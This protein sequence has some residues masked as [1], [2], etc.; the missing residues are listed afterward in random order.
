M[1]TW[2]K[3]YALV[4]AGAR[5]GQVTLT[6]ATH[7]FP[8]IS[9]PYYL[10][11]PWYDWAIADLLLRECDGMIREA[12]QSVYRMPARTPSLEHVAILRAAGE[13]HALRGEW[14]DA[15]RCS[16]FCLESNQGDSLDHA[17][18]DYVNAA[19]ACLELDD[20][21][22]YLRLRQEMTSRFKD[23]D[24]KTAERVIQVSVMRT[25]DDQTAAR[26]ETLA[27]VLRRA[28]LKQPTRNH[29]EYSQRLALYEYR[30]GNYLDAMDSARR[31]VADV[32]DVALPNAM[33]HVISAMSLQRI[34]NRSAAHLELERAKNLIETGFDLE[35]DMWHWRQWVFVRLLLQE[36]RGSIPQPPPP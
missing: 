33:E 12:E 34:G 36:A 32:R 16:N 7:I 18:M 31:S 3:G 9:E 2:T 5:E 26:L 30:R 8:G 29:T 27:A 11:A 10:Q 19:I 20:Q 14:S 21:N 4:Q 17:T 22:A 1:I 25:L 15:L 24:E 13:R 28:F 6:G 23:L 35:F